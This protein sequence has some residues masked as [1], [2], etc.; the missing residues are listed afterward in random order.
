MAKFRQVMFASNSSKFVEKCYSFFA[1]TNLHRWL[2]Q[3][4]VTLLLFLSFFV[5][6]SLEKFYN[7]KISKTLKKKQNKICEILINS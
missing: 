6:S 1:L 2:V 4:F 3:F 7:K 5:V